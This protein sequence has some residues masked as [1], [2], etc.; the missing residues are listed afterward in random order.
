[1]K[2]EEKEDTLP[3]HVAIIMD[4]NGRWAKRHQLPRFA[5]HKRGVE[6]VREVVKI[7]AKK[8]VEVLSLFAFSSENWRRP[9]KEVGLLMELLYT[10]LGREV[11]RLHNNNVQLRIIGDCTAFSPKLKK[12]LTE[13]EVLTKDNTGLILVVAV[14]YGGRWDVTQAARCLGAKIKAGELSPEDITEE[15]LSQNL[16]LNGLPDPDL[17]IRTGGEQRISNFMLWQL[18]YAEMYYTDTLWPDFN[19]NTLDDALSSFTNRQRR[20]GRTSEQIRQVEHA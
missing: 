13:G 15:L 20:F 12:R 6:A 19:E 18:A 17:F 8:G 3:R 16:A 5:G 10:S 2:K 7:C 14:N 4:G 9:K 11:K 1:M